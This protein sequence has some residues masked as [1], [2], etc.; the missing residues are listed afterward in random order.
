MLTCINVQLKRKIDRNDSDSYWPTSI[1]YTIQWLPFITI[2]EHT[3]N[4]I[5]PNKGR[6]T[7]LLK[8]FAIFQLRLF[9]DIH[10]E[11]GNVADEISI[12]CS[13]FNK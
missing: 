5:N 8:S 11:E 12:R 10:D 9:Y 1:K 7:S 13:N 4:I 3:S 6:I 2:I